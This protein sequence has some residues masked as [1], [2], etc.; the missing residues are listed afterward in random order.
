MPESMVSRSCRWSACTAN[1]LARASFF[2][3]GPWMFVAPNS[4]GL[5]SVDHDWT[6]APFSKQHTATDRMRAR[7]GRMVTVSGEEAR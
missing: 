6:V 4:P 3:S 5:T 7:S 2:G 1:G